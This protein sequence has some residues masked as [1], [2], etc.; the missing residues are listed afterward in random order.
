[1]FRSA[2]DLS[3][4]GPMKYAHTPRLKSVLVAR[5]SDRIFVMKINQEIKQITIIKHYNTISD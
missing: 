4:I 1:M 5:T 3:L 2:N